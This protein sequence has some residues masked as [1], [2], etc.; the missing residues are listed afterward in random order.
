MENGKSIKDLLAYLIEQREV[1]YK[2]MVESEPED[3]CNA[4]GHWEAYD[5]MV[6]M[7]EKYYL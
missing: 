1:W 7:T 2:E 3:R 6:S 5:Y 4:E